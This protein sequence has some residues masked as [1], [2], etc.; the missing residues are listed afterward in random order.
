MD[1]EQAGPFRCQL[2]PLF[3]F[4]KPAAGLR[5][6]PTDEKAWVEVYLL[7]RLSS[8]LCN[9]HS[10]CASLCIASPRRRAFAASQ[11]DRSI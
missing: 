6:G 1:G 4:L 2:Y 11:N 3:A 7:V 9:R 5:I 8:F 10:R